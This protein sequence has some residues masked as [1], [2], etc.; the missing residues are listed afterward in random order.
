M[1]ILQARYCPH[2]GETTYHRYQSRLRCCFTK[3]ECWEC[4]ACERHAKEDR[5][6]KERQEIRKRAA[7]HGNLA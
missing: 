6:R 2:C 1:S 4:V 7:G 5:R 3:D